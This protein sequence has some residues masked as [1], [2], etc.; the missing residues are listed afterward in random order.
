VTIGD[1]LD[2]ASHAFLESLSK[3]GPAVAA[4][5]VAQALP[6]LVAGDVTSW[7][8]VDREAG[9]IVWN[10]DL[11]DKIGPLL[12]AVLVSA[13]V[14]VVCGWIF[15]ATA[16]AGLRGRPMDAG[17]IVSRGLVSV[18][19]G[20]VLAAGVLAGIL[21]AIIVLAYLA[22]IA[23]PVAA[24]GAFAGVIGLIYVLLRL[25]F[26]TLAVF[27]GFGPIASF[28]E[29]WRLSE[30]GVTRVFGWGLIALLVGIGF[31]ILGAIA[32]T[33]LR[34]MHQQVL[35]QIVSGLFTSAAS[36]FA[37]FLLTV[38]YESQRARHAMPAP[39]AMAETTTPSL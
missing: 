29:S 35:A 16:I 7:Y 24:L 9:R 12:L 23:G 38:L 21:A 31:T 32:S 26:F 20:I 27:D 1:G 2:T 22:V 5:A 10:V 37:L 4:V 28:E 25:A 14:S 11:Q 6:P 19:A 15:S 18:V 13:V 39:S 36:V 34:G 33:V 30:R 8:T 17:W 3:W